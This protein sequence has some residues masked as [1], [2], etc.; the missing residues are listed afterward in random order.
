MNK[1]EKFLGTI[2]VAYKGALHKR[3]VFGQMGYIHDEMEKIGNSIDYMK[4]S[5]NY[6]RLLASHNMICKSGIEAFINKKYK[7]AFELFQRI[8]ESIISE[9][10]YT[11]A[12]CYLYGKGI[13]KNSKMGFR[14]LR[15]GASSSLCCKLL[16]ARCYIVGIS[17]CI[18][19]K[20]AYELVCEVFESIEAGI[21][22]DINEDYLMPDLMYFQGLYELEKGDEEKA[23]NHLNAVATD[24]DYGLAYYEIGKYFYNKGEKEKARIFLDHAKE[25]NINVSIMYSPHRDEVPERPILEEAE[26]TTGKLVTIASDCNAILKTGGDMVKIL[27]EFNPTKIQTAHTKAE[28]EKVLADRDLDEAKAQKDILATN[29]EAAKIESKAEKNGSEIKYTK[30]Q[31]KKE[32]WR[33]RADRNGIKD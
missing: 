7:K 33:K 25:K 2:K 30:S 12:I 11:L 22:N 28:V 6:I 13:K 17:V 4:Y 15:E 3:T 32:R 5:E 21:T 14:L 24:R 23:I 19:K 1:K 18:N 29:I 31:I 8:P 10:N 26:Q 20:K 16:L 27:E 9:R